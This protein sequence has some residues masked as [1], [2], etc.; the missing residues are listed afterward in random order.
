MKIL[1]KPPHV[2]WSV[3]PPILVMYAI[4]F[5]GNVSGLFYEE[6]KI[7]SLAMLALVI[8]FAFRRP[9]HSPT[10]IPLVLL[11]AVMCISMLLSPS[12]LGAWL[13][14]LWAGVVITFWMS[15]AVPVDQ[16][17][18]ALMAVIAVMTL[19][20][21][22]DVIEWE[23]QNDF[24]AGTLLRPTSALYNPN[25]VAPV[26]MIGIAL[27]LYTQRIL[28]LGLFIIVLVFTGSRATFLGMAMGAL[29]LAAFQ[30]PR[31][32]LKG[33]YILAALTLIVFLL[34]LVLHFRNPLYTLLERVDL[35]RAAVIAFLRQ[36]L[37]GIGPERYR[38]ALVE[39][40]R[41]QSSA[42]YTH[43]HN[44]FLHVAAELGMLGLLALGGIIIAGL[45]RIRKTFQTGNKQ[46]A[47]IAS[48]LLAGLIAQGL[49]DYVYWVLALVLMVLWAGRIIT[50]PRPQAYTPHPF[51]ISG[52][53]LAMT[54][55]LVM[56]G[57]PAILLAHHIDRQME[58]LYV[59]TTGMAFLLA[60]AFY[61]VMTTG[62]QADQPI[63]LE[64]SELPQP[65]NTR[66]VPN[67]LS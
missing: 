47:A 56:A 61:G 35:W 40:A 42:N 1:H 39:L 30:A 31:L 46:G 54:A 3:L 36:P 18:R 12:Y 22:Y 20:A 15:E 34:L 4:S 17:E 60:C 9:L 59:C 11:V 48:A 43:A 37:L 21:L 14:L 65:M 44:V 28:W 52:R 26:M 58:W 8:P 32:R 63:P 38:V 64:L 27:A 13:V 57:Y 67:P 7:F 66:Q 10:V 33:I 49:L 23:F 2:A 29:V 19:I 24:R 25:I 41:M 45:L 62:P 6:I 5:G 50:T 16:L 53:R 51:E 55:G